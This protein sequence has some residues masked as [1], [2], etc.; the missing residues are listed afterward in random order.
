MAAKRRMEA[1]VPEKPARSAPE[2]RWRIGVLAA[3]ILAGTFIVHSGSLGNDFVHWDDDKYVYDNED[4]RQLDGRS[5]LRFFT[6]SYLR[7]YQPVTML[8]YAWDYR[9][10]GLD[11][12][13]YHRTNVLF[14]LLNTLLVFWAVSLLT[15]QTAIAAVSAVFFGVHP[16]HV[17]SVAWIS[18]RKDVLYSFFYLGSWIA[19]IRYRRSGNRRGF[20]FAALF[21]FLLS[22]FSKSAAVTLPLVLILTDFYLGRKTRIQNHLDKIP[23]FILAAVFGIVSLLTQRVVGSDWD[24]VTGYSLADRLFL[25]A[26]ALTFYIA[27][28]VFPAGLSA[29]HPLPLKPEGLLPIRYYISGPVF[30]VLPWILLKVHRSKAG[31]PLKKDVLFGALFFIFTIAP[32]LFIPVG[33]AVA[34][35]R[36]TYV[37]YIGLSVILGRLYLA[38]RQR[39][40]SCSFGVRHVPTAALAMMLVVFAHAAYARSAVWKDT[41]TLFSD[42]I[43]KYPETGIAYNNRGNVRRDER[44]FQGA[45]EDYNRA[46]GLNYT[47]AYNN[48]G[49][50]R[51][52]MKD[53]GGAIEDFTRALQGKAGRDVAYYNRGIA[54]LNLGDFQ[55]A[56]EDFTRAVEINPRHA[57]AYNNRGFVRYEKLSD[58][59]GA[60]RDFD[61]AIR[62]RPR[63][64]EIYYNRGN[65]KA[66][67]GDYA[68]A[69]MDYTMALRMKPEYG[70]AYFNKGVAL[71]R[72]NETGPACS[73]WN[74][75]SELGIA[76]AAKLIQAYCRPQGLPGK[77]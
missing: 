35:E 49:I 73:D 55:G 23:F 66:L 28:S 40:K 16:L 31:A 10:G 34:A 60:I 50:L 27:K 15:R 53:Y 32:V 33:Q 21:L 65:A 4:I 20:Y 47:D 52:R 48:R 37:P 58:S 12:R 36:Y 8:S 24:Y 41:R 44:D 11:A 13:T 17:E 68:G 76:P 72:L 59:T 9:I 61:A 38:A 75:A 19:Y 39:L 63:E 64:P 1:A 51:N 18:E 67:A 70:E 5:V 71:L 30:I 26:Y 7:M 2:G 43:E 22:L 3:V 69:I 46:I 56:V 54:R 45:M 14:H 74:R 25:G 57:D 6:S 62:L 29:I 42:V 77:P